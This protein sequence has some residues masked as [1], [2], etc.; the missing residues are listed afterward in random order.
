MR[1]VDPGFRGDSIEDTD[2][3][4]CGMSVHDRD[5]AIEGNGGRGQVLKDVCVVKTV[6]IREER[7]FSSCSG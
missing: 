1:N 6:G 7:V 4:V 3:R 2:S 5:G